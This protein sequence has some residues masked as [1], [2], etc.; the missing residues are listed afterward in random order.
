MKHYIVYHKEHVSQNDWQDGYGDYLNIESVEYGQ[1]FGNN[2]KEAMQDWKNQNTWM[3]K[4]WFKSSD[5]VFELYDNVYP[6]VSFG[7]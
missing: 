7:R 4:N 1:A 2:E 3:P 6:P 5:W